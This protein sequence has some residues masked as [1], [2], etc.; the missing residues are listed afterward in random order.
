LAR[1][2]D[3]YADGRILREELKAAIAGLVVITHRELVPWP[4]S[5]GMAGGS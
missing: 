3:A 2:L 1:W 4:L 5:A